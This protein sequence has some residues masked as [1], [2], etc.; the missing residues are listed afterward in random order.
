[1]TNFTKSRDGTHIAYS[2]M[3]NGS[4]LILV[5]GAFCH[6]KF[7]A[8]VKLP[9][10]LASYFTVY[11][12][13]R[14]GRGESSNTLPYSIER[15]FEDLQAINEIAG[16]YSYV[17]GISSGAAL[18]LEAV[19]YG[20]NIKKLVVFEAPYI[21]DKSR[22]PLPENYLTTIQNFLKEN[23]RSKAVKYFMVT[24]VGLPK[25]VV[26]MMQMMPAWRQMKQI[27]HTLEYDTL[28]L[29]NNG[30]G[31]AFNKEDWTKVDKPVL[32]ISGSKSEKWSQH[33]MKQLA[34]VLPKGKHLNLKGQSHLVNPKV[35]AP[36][37]INFLKDET[38][39]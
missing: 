22:V 38:V 15:E 17:Y 5:D 31:E 7:G 37:I 23:K 14:R 9:N 28:L 12:Y 16:G 21:V 18:V 19:K 4:P 3:G 39:H 33:S 1:M 11:T 32:V 13:D 8:N 25:F 30:S 2:K 10:H 29:K 6:R 26:W 20:L 35:I 36:H 24:G 27:A 34:E